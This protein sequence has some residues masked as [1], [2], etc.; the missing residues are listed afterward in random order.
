MS[1]RKG[2]A[3]AG[4][5]VAIVTP[6]TEGKLDVAKLKTQIEFQ[7][8]AGVHFL[9]PVGTTGESPTLTHDEHERVISEVIQ[10]A[11]GRCKV[12]AGTGSNCTAEALRLTRRAEKEGA[13]ASL[14]VPRPFGKKH[15]TGNHR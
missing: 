13:D 9:V 15:R 6:F 10:L 1:D 2:S 12:M 14:Q 4:V 5:G 8:A 7:I 11:S 3:F